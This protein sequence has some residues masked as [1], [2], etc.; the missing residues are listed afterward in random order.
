MLKWY[1][2]LVNV[3]VNIYIYLVKSE[4]DEQYLSALISTSYAWLPTD[5]CR[6]CLGINM[7]MLLN[8]L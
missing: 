6:F 4:N 7:E 1:L 5:R 2:R 8:K 3:R